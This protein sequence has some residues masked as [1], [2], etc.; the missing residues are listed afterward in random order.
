MPTLSV[1][2]QD[3]EQDSI[4]LF[5]KIKVQYNNERDFTNNLYY[6]PAS[7]SGYSNSSFTQLYIGIKDANEKVN[8]D[9][10]G[11]NA[12]SY[13]LQ[14]NSFQSVSPT[15]S[16]WGAA[17][18]TNISNRAVKWNENLD[19]DRISPYS[20][21]DSVG[22]NIS[23]EKYQFLGGFA[24]KLNRFTIGLEG[25]YTAQLGAR[26]RD[27][28]NKTIT[29]DL[30][31]KFGT[32]YNFYKDLEVGAFVQVDKYTQNNRLSFSS[33][34]GYPSV[35][36]MNSFGYFNY[37]FSS[38]TATIDNLYEQIGYEFG[39]QI[40][41]KQG[42]D[43][44]ILAKMGNK[45]L[46][47]S[48]K[49]IITSYY[50]IADVEDNN[51]LVE[52]AKFFN[53]NNQ[54]VGIK[55]QYEFKERIGTEYGY[56]N[57]TSPIQ[58]IYKQKTFKRDETN[59]GAELFYQYQNTNFT[60]AAIPFVA[61]QEFVEKRLRPFNGEK[62]ESL[63]FGLALDFKY[64]V[65][66]DNIVTLKPYF[67]HKAVSNHISVLELG[68]IESVN[69]WVNADYAY[70]SSDVTQF[71][72]TLRYDFKLKKTPGIFAALDWQNMKVLEKNNTFTTVK[73]GVTF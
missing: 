68:N 15:L 37:L 1:F 69:N 31:V 22:G 61:Y 42:K 18:Y 34:L 4:P 73:V 29:S 54:R 45:N 72:G 55:A 7:M 66:K 50:D 26:S 47:K 30:E 48:T 3:V 24:K 41:N 70:L 6:N 46:T 57:I 56:S 52:G 9:V 10:L 16:L 28:R 12:S 13:G 5:E 21:A 38:A 59:Y 2:G 60:L 35:Y 58:L 67:S 49:G 71:G 62:W 39:G 51:Y 63:T 17:S 33:L 43:F 53:F 25:K 19:Y 20:V 64:N 23:I 14:T 32:N 44:Y 36:Q 11:K 65:A 40:T 27:P 8:R